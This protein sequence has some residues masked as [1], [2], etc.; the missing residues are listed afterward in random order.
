MAQL[1]LDWGASV[2]A[3]DYQQATP[4]H[5]A[6]QEGHE[7][8][9]ELLLDRGASLSAVDY[10]ESAPLQIACMWGHEKSASLV[11]DR[12]VKLEIAGTWVVMHERSEIWH[13]VIITH[14]CTM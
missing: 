14:S 5:L 3:A 6:C 13:S 12:S 2:G 7:E 4:L 11:L 1:L 9:I 10:R 8:L